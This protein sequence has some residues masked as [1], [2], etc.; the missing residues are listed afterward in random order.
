[1]DMINT[2]CTRCP[3]NKIVYVKLKILKENLSLFHIY[4]FMK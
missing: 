3:K 2:D 1:M 4:K